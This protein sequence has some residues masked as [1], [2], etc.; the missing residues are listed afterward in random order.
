MVTEPGE[1]GRILL[2]VLDLE[3]DADDAR[4]G[5]D[6]G[7]HA[8]HAAG[9]PG[10]QLVGEPQHTGHPGPHVPCGTQRQVGDEM[11]AIEV[12]ELDRRLPLGEELAGVAVDGAYNAGKRRV[13]GSFASRP[14]WPA[15]VPASGSRVPV[16]RGRIGFSQRPP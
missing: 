10:I 7:S 3:G 5:A 1:P 13:G 16:Q 15:G 8:E 2:P 14:E 4:V 9:V 12:K 11:E 6:L